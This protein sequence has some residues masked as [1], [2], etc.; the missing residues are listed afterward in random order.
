M[1]QRAGRMFECSPVAAR[2]AQ[3]PR[4]GVVRLFGAAAV[5]TALWLTLLAPGT[6]LA[7]KSACTAGGQGYYCFWSG[8]S[9]TGTAYGFGPGIGNAKWD[10]WTSAAPGLNKAASEYNYRDTYVTWVATTTNYQQ[11]GGHQACLFPGEE[12]DNLQTLGYPPNGATTAYQS[13]RGFYMSGSRTSCD[14]SSVWY[15]VS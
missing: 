2:G 7:A 5:C 12:D 8:I 1:I 6:A 4:K 13:I 10:Q 3:Q 11:Y 15:A 14:I 9:Y